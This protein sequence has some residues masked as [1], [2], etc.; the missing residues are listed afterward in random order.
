MKIIRKGKPSTEIKNSIDS[1]T[2]LLQERHVW[3]VLIVDDEPDIH[4]ITQLNLRGF[5]FE[6]RH[7]EFILAYSAEQARVLLGEHPDIALALIDVVMETDDAGLALVKYI[8]EEL[9]YKMIRLVIRTGQPGQAPERFVIDNFDIDDYKDKTELTTQKLYTTVRS[10]LKSFRDLMAI[11]MNRKGLLSILQATPEIYTYGQKSLP[12]FFKGMLTQIVSLHNL[13]TNAVISTLDGMV[14]TINEQEVKIRAGTG[15]FAE[16]DY[17]NERLQEIISTCSESIMTNKKSTKLRENSLIITLNVE[18][19]AI[20]FVY[21]E[22]ITEIS[23]ADLSL[24]KLFANQCSAVLE[25]LQLHFDLERS[26]NHAID[27]LAVIAEFRDSNTGNHINRIAMYTTLI[28]LELG[29]SEEEAELYGQSARLHD[30]GKVGIPDNILLKKG[31]LN[32]EEFEIIKLHTQRGVDIL[33]GN[34]Q[35]KLASQV[36]LTH[37][38]RW[39]GTGYPAGLKG[40]EIPLVSRIVSV[41]DVFDA[42]ISK[43][44]YK[45]AWPIEDAIHEIRKMAGT[46]FDADIVDTFLELFHQGRFNKIMNSI[47]D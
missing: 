2:E 37:H 31:K 7:L 23:E 20:G 10:A 21:L 29:F 1:H 11:D 47:K 38:E 28:A 40:D 42:L 46:Q 26:Y 36:C 8:R 34:D 18:Q 45:E 32:V 44:C 14:A 41:I 25:S 24:I 15:D 33:K 6:N 43:R 39:D 13:D 4:E 27:M 17:K 9:K 35:F 22:P 12:L 5:Q 16:K 3:K 30:V 19:K